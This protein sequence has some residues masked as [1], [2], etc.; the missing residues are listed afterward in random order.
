[1]A[2]GADRKAA[3]PP[4]PR[5]PPEVRWTRPADPEA[6]AELDPLCA[7]VGPPLIHR[8]SGIPEDV[9]VESLVVVAWNVHREAGRVADFV[10]DL[11]SG[12]LTGEPV[13]HFVLL[14][15]EVVRAPSELMA[16]EGSRRPGRID[17]PSPDPGPLS[18]EEVAR[19]EELNLFYAPSIPRWPG[20]SHW[21]RG[22]G[23][24]AILSTLPLFDLE[25][26]ELPLQRQRRV[27][28]AATVRGQRGAGIPWS[29]RVASV[30]LE[31]RS[32]WRVIHRSLGVDRGW[33]AARLVAALEE[34]ERVVVG[35]DFNTWF[36]G[37]AEPAAR[38]MRAHFPP[39]CGLPPGGTI[40]LPFLPDMTLDY[41]FF[42]L[43]GAWSAGYRVLP[44]TYGSDHK[45]LLATI[46]LDGP[47]GCSGDATR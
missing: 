37:A 20:W 35:G 1:M 22:D 6:R 14:L 9:A 21:S 2:S 26:L 38:L 18:F 31:N 39:S 30:H 19:G 3:S 17:A 11:R 23:G 5:P 12:R 29:L 10:D 7:A 13:P 15:Q 33:Q 25:A 32:R 27:T 42:R 8:P 44:D 43:P 4:A 41:V 46:R 24:T 47:G 40:D 45:P 28:V 36:R 16:S 34:E